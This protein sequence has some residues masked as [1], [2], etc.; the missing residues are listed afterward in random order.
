MGPEG[1]AGQQGPPGIE[2]PRGPGTRVTFSGVVDSLGAASA[3][4]PPEAGTAQNLPLVSCYESETGVAWFVVGDGY[5]LDST[6]CVVGGD[7]Q[8]PL[9]VVMLQGIPGWRYFISVVY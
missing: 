3:V 7:D 2:G 8:G 1:P 4:L 5:S 9:V 6:F